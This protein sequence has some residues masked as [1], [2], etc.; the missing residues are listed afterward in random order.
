V[1]N[2][3][4]TL[5]RCLDSIQQQSIID[6][7]EIIILDSGSTDDSLKIA[8]SYGVKVISIDPLTFDHGLTRNVGVQH[9]SGELIYFTVQDAFLSSTD[10]LQKM[11]DHFNDAEIMAVVGHQAVPHELDKNPMLWYKPISLPSPKKK[12]VQEDNWW[13]TSTQKEQKELVAWDNVVSIYKRSALIALPFVQTKFAEDWIWSFT[14]LKKGWKLMYDPSI[15]AYHYHHLNYRYAYATTI[16]VNYHLF[17]HLH[18]TPDKQSLLIPVLKDVWHL[19]RNNK[20]TFAKKI[21]WIA[22]NIEAKLAQWNANRHFSK[23]IKNGELSK[24]EIIYNKVC[25]SIPMG[26]QN[27]KST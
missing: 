2:G 22:Y 14:A 24:A 25:T 3:A 7:M 4:M 8:R 17:K 5:K 11:S 10:M 16:A 15:V 26:K 20:I 13:R 12:F 1:K 21:Y 6:D 19:L 23:K 27:T 18:F 9:A